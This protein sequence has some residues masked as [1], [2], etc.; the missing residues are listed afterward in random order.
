[1]LLIGRITFEAILHPYREYRNPNMPELSRNQSAMVVATAGALGGIALTMLGQLFW[2]STP[3]PLDTSRSRR[4]NAIYAFFDSYAE[5]SPDA[6]LEHIASDFTHQVLPSSLQM[7]LRDRKAFA[8]HAKGITS[9]FKTFAMVPQVVYEDVARNI[10]IAHCKMIGQLHALGPWENECVM[11]MQ[12]SN[13]G[14]KIVE[15]REFVDSARAGLLREKLTTQLD[16]KKA[17]SIMHD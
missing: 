11:W 4:L 13:D 10:V 7:P 14:T 15:M 2:S 5:L 6:L 1:L 9:I 16:A 3:L 12:M 8:A 17:E